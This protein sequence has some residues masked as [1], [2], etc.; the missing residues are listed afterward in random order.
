MRFGCQLAGLL[1]AFHATAVAAVTPSVDEL[2]TYLHIDKAERENLLRGKSLST[3]VAEGAETELGVGVV[4]FMPAPVEKL[5]NFVRSGKMF[6][7]DHDVIAVGELKESAEAADFS[8]IVFTP[9]QAKEAASLL[10]VGPGMRFNL[11]GDE[12]ETFRALKKVVKDKNMIPA[13]AAQAYQHLLLQRYRAYRQGGLPAI[14]P[15]DRDGGR[16]SRPGDE[17]LKALQESLLLAEHFPE[18]HQIIHDYPQQQPNDVIH[19][20]FWMNQKVENRPTFMLTHRLSVIR[21]E[22]ALMAERQFYVG[23]SYNSLFVLAGCLPMEDGTVV[24]Y[25]NH[26]STDQVAGFGSAL[27]HSIGRSQMRDE[28][29]KNF[30]QIRRELQSP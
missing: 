25:S 16:V 22:G 10:E 27:R 7:T 6:A 21:P 15:Y 8:G 11:S 26:T 17:L 19:R 9:E 28:I 30:E 20:F 29:V 18:I 1:C 3:E 14:A 2:L 24:L 12:I 23:H 5:V 4:M 13:A